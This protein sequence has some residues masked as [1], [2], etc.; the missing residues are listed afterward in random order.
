MYDVILFGGTDEG[1]KIADF[2]DEKNISYIVCVAT[3]YGA[4]ILNNRNV[5]VGRMI[6]EEMKIFFEENNVK[7]VVDATHP[8]AYKVTENIKKVCRCK[9]IRV[10]REDC[11]NSINSFRDI[12]SVV[13]YLHNT[14]G[15]ILITTGSK[16]IEE[17]ASVCDRAYARV[18]PS[19]ES[20]RLCVDA[21]F[22]KKRIICMQ[23]PFSKEFNSVLIRE[24][25]IKYLVTKSS[26]ISGGFMEKLEAAAENGTEC[27]VIKRPSEE[28]GVSVT[29]AQ[30]MILEW[31]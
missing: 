22:K 17:F 15:N 16:E 24:L 4:E 9:Y 13:E 18:L 23:G 2:L 21:G 30:R 20:L 29:E 19:E 28:S 1:H 7:I 12:K 27:L 31:L 14:S 25:D 6:A 3:D 8:Y 11:K 5:R 10:L 26:G